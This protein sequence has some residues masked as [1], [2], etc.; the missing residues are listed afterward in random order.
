MISWYAQKAFEYKN[1]DLLEKLAKFV[2]NKPW[3]YLVSKIK[4]RAV[5][6][7]LNGCSKFILRS[8]KYIRPSK[9]Q[10]DNETFIA[11]LDWVKEKDQQKKANYLEIFWRKYSKDLI[12]ERIAQQNYI[13]YLTW[14]VDPKKPRGP[15]V[16]DIFMALPENKSYS[17]IVE[18]RISRFLK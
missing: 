5:K 11:A 6:I 15:S 9:K 1:W 18:K 17:S 8:K 3:L 14:D 7:N 16:V 2:D 13:N 4:G 10:C 12:Y